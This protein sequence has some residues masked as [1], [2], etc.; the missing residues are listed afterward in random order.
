MDFNRLRSSAVQ[1]FL[2]GDADHLRQQILAND[3]NEIERKFLANLVRD[4][5][6]KGR[7]GPKSKSSK[8]KMAALIRFWRIE[9][10]GWTKVDALTKEIEN[11]LKVSAT[12]AR[13]Y[14]RQVD[15]PQSKTQWIQSYFAGVEIDNRRMAIEWG[16]TEL[17]ELYRNNDLKPISDK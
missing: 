16:D 2:G 11:T 7:R 5:I 13:K 17:I 10:D 9:V 6:P 1:R 15:A 14:L 8:P 4:N 12:M 3:L